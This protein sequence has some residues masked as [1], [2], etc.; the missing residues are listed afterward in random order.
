MT[1][2]QLKSFLGVAKDE[3]VLAGARRVSVTSALSHRCSVLSIFLKCERSIE[4]VLNREPWNVTKK[5]ASI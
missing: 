3:I 5:A 4:S 2:R 1:G